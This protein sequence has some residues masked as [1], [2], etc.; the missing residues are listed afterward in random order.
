MAAIISREP[1]RDLLVEEP[2][3]PSTSGTSTWSIG[4][5]RFGAS[6][7]M[8]AASRRIEKAAR[9]LAT[10]Y[11]VHT[12]M[13]FQQHIP[14]MALPNERS[15]V[16]QICDLIR[17]ALS[18]FHGRRRSTSRKTIKNAYQIAFACR[19]A[20]DH[21]IFK[22]FDDCMFPQE[23][24]NFRTQI[25]NLGEAAVGFAAYKNKVRVTQCV[26]AFRRLSTEANAVAILR[27]LRTANSLACVSG[28]NEACKYKFRVFPS[29]F[30]FVELRQMAYD[31][32][33]G[34]LQLS[35]RER[36]NVLEYEAT[37]ARLRAISKI[38]LAWRKHMTENHEFLHRSIYDAFIESG[39]LSNSEFRE[40]NL[41]GKIRARISE[42]SRLM[43]KRNLSVQSETAEESRLAEARLAEMMKPQYVPGSSGNISVSFTRDGRLVIKLTTE[44]SVPIGGDRDVAQQKWIITISLYP[45]KNGDGFS[46]TASR[47][48]VSECCNS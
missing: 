5:P 3:G 7:H 9:L 22:H 37:R 39:L 38:R 46:R 33:A 17:P 48:K 42:I 1:S 31:R 19:R 8:E 44:S 23:L 13:I 18:R 26:R 47:R 16:Q 43:A 28:D 40:L 41:Y 6:R 12:W 25:E 32:I 21:H 29:D 36:E 27:A 14:Q 20:L 4:S 2:S 11:E 35:S 45:Q 30:R 10:N 24:R 15:G 34:K